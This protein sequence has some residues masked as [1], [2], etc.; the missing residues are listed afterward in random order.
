M[1]HHGQRVNT[2][3][4]TERSLALLLVGTCVAQLAATL[5]VLPSQ[6][7]TEDE[8]KYLGIGTN[9]F[10]GNGPL[11]VFGTFFRFHSPLWSAV[12][13]APKA[14]FGVDPI[15]WAHV[16]TVV[17]ACAVLVFVAALGWRFSPAVGVIA[18]ATLLTIPYF[19]A[20]GRTH[21]LDMPAAA[22]SLGYVVLGDLAVRR[23]SIRLAAVAGLVFGIAFLTKEIAL[24]FA[25]VPFF[26][27]LVSGRPPAAVAR[28]AAVAI[29]PAALST[30]WWFV[31]FA[32]YTGEVY[33]LGT[34]AWTLVPLTAGGLVAVV[35][36]WFAPRLVG[37]SPA[38]WPTGWP[39]PTVL[40]GWLG[41][42][43]WTTLL[44]VFFAGTRT[45]VGLPFLNASNV[46]FYL[47]R[48][49]PN[50]R[51]V[52]LIGVV[53]CGLAVAWRVWRASRRFRRGDER[54]MPAD[55]G[56]PDL[57]GGR[58]P[59]DD[60]RWIQGVD[61][62]VVA[63]LCG[64]PLVLLVV[65]VGELP[66][67]YIAQIGIALAVGSAG[68]LRFIQAGILRSRTTALAAG[69]AC[70]AAA[71]AVLVLVSGLSLTI[72]VGLLA[73]VTGLV[74]ALL[75]TRIVPIA[76]WLALRRPALPIAL[77]G[78][79][80]ATG[81]AFSTYSLLRSGSTSLV[82]RTK[83]EAVATAS[84]WVRAN[85]PIGGRVAFADRLA[86][87]TAD[88]LQGSYDL[89]QQR[90]SQDVRFDPN[91][92]LGLRMRGTGSTGDWAAIWRA[93]LSPNGFYGYERAAL[94]E[95][96]RSRRIDIWILT[97]PTGPNS[98]SPIVAALEH[99]T[100]IRRLAHWSWPYPAGRLET[101]VFGIDPDHLRLDDG[102]LYISPDALDSLVR[103][104]EAHRDRAGA[105]ARGLL[106][107]AVL[108]PE[109]ASSE[110]LRARL[111]ALA[112]A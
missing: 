100:G 53:G 10:A 86:Y 34:P 90:E 70:G 55:S 82:D 103:Q 89:V 73:A 33:R 106:E 36:G 99:A 74:L 1:V 62:L 69:L 64:L 76:A 78:L 57:S 49:V 46:S 105:T 41:T 66:R 27:A 29:V 5:I 83:A 30:L 72:R 80:V 19:T 18:A 94:E 25:P 104:L 51:M 110:A 65:S 67:H 92:P 8:A 52:L 21:G 15:A 7:M 42:I 56:A 45:S 20:L 44:T 111:R 31:V 40:T 98:A 60:S 24:P 22:L 97:G 37:S 59:L 35:A 71:I 32:Q 112:G 47:N 9:I 6:F 13:V 39:S 16:V 96:L 3:I 91:A 43:A 107:R 101:T 4:R 17:S 88:V 79:A 58:G 102:H 14:W 68:W 85:V 109:G 11:T 48:W 108:V 87:E 75:A 54:V 26:A 81:I 2:L 23:T 38:R 28:L 12:M 95:A 61:H 77:A 93:P 84:A 50:T 63:S